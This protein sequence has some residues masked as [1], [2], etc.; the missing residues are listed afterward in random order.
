MPISRQMIQL[1]TSTDSM[2]STH[3]KQA[4]GISIA[5]SNQASIECE[6]FWGGGI[7]STSNDESL[8]S[9]YK[10]V[11]PQS[12]NIS[13]LMT[14][15]LMVEENREHHLSHIWKRSNIN[16]KKWISTL[17]QK[18]MI[19]LEEHYVIKM[20]EILNQLSQEKHHQAKLPRPNC[21]GT[22][23]VFK[24]TTSSIWQVIEPKLLLLPENIWYFIIFLSKL[25][26]G[27]KSLASLLC[28][29]VQRAQAQWSKGHAK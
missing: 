15:S 13:P 14:L 8:T 28:D 7:T 29:W 10:R 24:A 19:T 1:K 12:A 20:P 22:R 11:Q 23:V 26:Y 18:Y 21:P 9:S 5:H 2:R 6:I 16:R 27:S 25:G 17:S 4:N 3:W